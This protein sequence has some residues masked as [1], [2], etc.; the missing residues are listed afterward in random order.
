MTRI[1]IFLT[2][3]FTVLAFQ[4]GAGAQDRNNGQENPKGTLSGYV[5]DELGPVVGAAVFVDKTT[6]GDTSGAEGEFTLTGLN[7]KDK[8]VVSLIGY[9]TQEFRY[10]GQDTVRIVLTEV[11]SMLDGVV[12][13]ALGIE[14]DKMALSYGI[15]QVDSD[16][17]T[18]V[19]DAN[20][21]NSLSGKVAGV[22][23][24]SGAAGSGSA[25]RV[26]MRGMKSIEKSNS[27][28][29]VIDGV[30]MYNSGSKGASGAFGGSMGTEAAA[31]INP[32]DIESVSML[33]GA[34]AAAL[35]GSAAANGVVLINTKR[36]RSGKARVTVSN[37][38]TMSNVSFMPE[39]QSRY[40]GSTM[41]SWDGGKVDS[42]Y[43]PSDFFRTGMDIINSVTL[44]AGSDRNQTFASA[45]STNSTGI[46]PNSKYDRYNF[47]V[48]NTTYFGKDRFV[49]DIGA[50]YI[51][52]YDRNLVAQGR[53]NN[54]LPGLYMFPRGEDYT[55]MKNYQYFDESLGYWQPTWSYGSGD[56]DTQNPYWIMN[57]MTRET[58]RSRYILNASLK[59]NIT[60]WMNITARGNVDNTDWNS[61]SEYMAG[62][63]TT[64]SGEYGQ[65]SDQMQRD[66][67]FYGDVILN[68]AKIWD[69]WSLNVNAGGSIND[70]QSAAMSASGRLKYPNY[71]AFN[72][73]NLEQGF[74]LGQSAWHEQ[75]Q[76]VF[77]SVEAGWKK[78]LY[79]TVT[80]RNDW[81]SQLAFSS[82][83]SFFYPS[84]GLSGVISNL[85]SLPEWFNLLKVRASYSEVASPFARYLSNPAY[86]YNSSSQTWSKPSTYPAQNLKPEKT[87][88]WE[89]GLNMYF[90][91]CLNFDITYYHTNTFNQTI[92]APLS[93]STGY[94]N[95]IAQTGNVQNEG[96]ELAVSFSKNWNGFAWDSGFTYSFNRNV[97]RE[98]AHGIT[99]P[100]TGN[101][102]EITEIQKT[103]LGYDNVAPKIILREGGSM[104]DIYDNHRLVQNDDGTLSMEQT[105]WEYMGSL[106]PDGNLGW[107]NSF[108]YKGI[109][110][111]FVINARIGG[112][113]YSATQGMLDY[114]GAS[115]ASAVARDNGGVV[116]NGVKYDAQQYYQTIASSLGG[117][118]RYYLYDAT[119]VRLQELSL[120]YTLPKR[121]FRYKA[122]VTLGFIARNL[123]M[124]WCEA[125]FDPELT[126]AADSEFYQGVDYFML[127]A[128]RNLGFSLKIGF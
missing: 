88:S 55:S 27:A 128:T 41:N 72:N 83:S 92:Y 24:S 8:I 1:R 110:L 56:Y 5:Y 13:T 50:S 25:T 81:A 43:N 59:W 2:A 38:T 74:S 75:T 26:V 119:N 78:A 104:L 124:I 89:V 117:Y 107:N 52:Q 67:T 33:T 6:N 109:S 49:L 62:T 68:I 90:F 17:I 121:W 101:S 84:V 32:E 9:E 66:K 71:F 102:V 60:D 105:D 45:S 106:A 77:A 85:V 22:Q 82:Q 61:T 86:T 54:P 111:G 51:L 37:S 120:N 127:P 94:S 40:G 122:N 48:R 10:T 20:F 29:Y 114:N 19:K 108:S 47:S 30:P 16:L 39:L 123:W 4:A 36:G 125:P 112:K 23:I 18:A 113:V 95:F 28:L 7:R 91:D 97:I 93:S 69:D 96:I 44:S 99:D 70:L 58:K 115:E 46:L 35:Y 42:N 11:T 12:V 100:I 126:G 116:Y 118:G 57:N 31:D 80:G 21:V 34:S 63:L 65:Y 87:K 15:Q 103:T 64:F 14:R 53:F 76:S 98:L 79:L 3:A 73:L